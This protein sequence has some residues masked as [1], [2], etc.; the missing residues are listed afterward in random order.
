M[1]YKKNPPP[2]KIQDL[3][4]LHVYHADIFRKKELQ[5]MTENNKFH[6]N[7]SIIVCNIDICS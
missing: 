6:K 2:Q 7:R 3:T 4:S 1:L 5:D